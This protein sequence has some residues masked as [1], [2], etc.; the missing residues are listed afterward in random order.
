MSN[1]H[2]EK[3]INELNE[4]IRIKKEKLRNIKDT[5]LDKYEIN[6]ERL[7][8]QQEINVLKEEKNMLEVLKVKYASRNEVVA[9]TVE[10][11]STITI[12]FDDEDP[13][14]YEISAKSG[15]CRGVI[16]PNS[17]IVKALLG[18]QA[19]YEFTY[20]DFKVKLLNVEC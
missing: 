1:N 14:T 16:S 11:G 6:E 12:Q 4:K 19:G 15:S 8:L 18:K 2:I 17:D 5:G 20:N 3:K 7:S 10:I 13:E 9:G